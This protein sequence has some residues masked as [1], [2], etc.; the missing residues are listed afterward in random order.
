M[1]LALHG[2]GMNEDFFALLLQKLFPRPLRFLIPR[3]PLPAAPAP[4]ATGGV[5]NGGS[6]YSYDGDQDR[7]R[8]ELRRA[9]SELVQLLQETEAANGWRPSRRFLIGFSQ[10]GYCGAWTALRRPDVFSGMAIVGARVK[11]EFLEEEMTAA[12]DAGFRALL[13]HGERDRSV[14][15]ESAERG[16]AAL[17]SA[18]VEVRVLT[19][20]AGHTIGRAQSG[21][22]GEWLDEVAG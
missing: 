17:E 7:F 4:A 16:R 12:A 10:G 2:W 13:I 22:I 1:V 21:A 6:W 5:R 3:A 8:T 11:T 9:E 20:D 18:G 15:P 14:S 19:F